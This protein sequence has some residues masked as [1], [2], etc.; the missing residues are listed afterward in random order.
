M[1]TARCLFF[2]DIKRPTI[3]DPAEWAIVREMYFDTSFPINDDIDSIERLER[4]ESK[5]RK[6][7][8]NSR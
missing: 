6:L 2:M 4:M 5:Q 1:G 3:S 8:N 7:N